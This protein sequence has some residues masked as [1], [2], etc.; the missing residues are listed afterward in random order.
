MMDS[1]TAEQFRKWQVF[2]EKVPLGPLSSWIQ[3][4]AICAAIYNTQSTGD[5]T[6]K[7]PSDFFMVLKRLEEGA[8][9]K[10]NVGER[11]ELLMN[12]WGCEG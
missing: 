11:F 1:L 9:S 7:K 3:A 6:L 5:S 4:G 8:A 12:A 2:G 10:G